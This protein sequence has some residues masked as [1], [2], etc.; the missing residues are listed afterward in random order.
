M[1]RLVG[2]PVHQKAVSVPRQ[3]TDL[4]CVLGPRLGHIW[5]QP[6]GV[7]HIDNSP[8]SKINQHIS[9]GEN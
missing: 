9:S 7:A 6:V 5:D 8:F 1:A 4:G 3:G 2:A